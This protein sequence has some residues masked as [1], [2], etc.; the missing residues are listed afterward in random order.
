MTHEALGLDRI[1]SPIG[2]LWIA[3]D[4]RARLWAVDFEEC[5]AR[6][7]SLLHTQHGRSDA[8]PSARA[9]RA[10]RD[11]FARYFAGELTAL[12]ALEVHAGGRAFQRRVWTALRAIPAGTTLAY[13]EL[14]HALGRPTASRAVGHANGSNPLGIVVPCATA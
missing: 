6:L 9:P 4:S 8:L 7:R 5:E 2:T 1:E 10:V 14:A 3:F 12:D 13:G 11:A